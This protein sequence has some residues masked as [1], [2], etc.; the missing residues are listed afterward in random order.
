MH[1]RIERVLVWKMII[2]SLGH[3]RLF[4]LGTLAGKVNS[5]IIRYDK[6]M[7]LKYY[8]GRSYYEN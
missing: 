1:M 8:Q 4:V 3:F 7:H 6:K 2:Y 5:D